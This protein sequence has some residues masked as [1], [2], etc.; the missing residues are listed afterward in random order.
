MFEEKLEDRKVEPI[1][2]QSKQSLHIMYPS[3]KDW[4]MV[5]TTD[6]HGW[7]QNMAIK[8]KGEFIIG[9]CL[10]LYSGLHYILQKSFVI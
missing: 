6:S 10:Y 4:Y 5:L 8:I 9:N 2:Q 7:L 1:I 3:V